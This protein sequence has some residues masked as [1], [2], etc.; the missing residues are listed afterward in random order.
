VSFFH[1]LSPDVPEDE[2]GSGLAPDGAEPSPGELQVSFY[3]LIR[4][5]LKMICSMMAFK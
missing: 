4:D 2:G 1:F 5:K 3:F